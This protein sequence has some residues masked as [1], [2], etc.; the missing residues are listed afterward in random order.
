MKDA[1]AVA[2]AIEESFGPAA[3]AM[4]GVLRELAEAIVAGRKHLH[5]Y[6]AADAPALGLAEMGRL[7]AAFNQAEA[8]VQDDPEALSRVQVA[9]L[10]LR[11]LWARRWSELQQRAKLAGTPGPARPTT[12]R[13]AGRS[14]K[15]P[16]ATT[17]RRSRRAHRSLGLRSS[18]WPGAARATPPGCEALDPQH[19]DFQD[20]GFLFVQEARWAARERD[21]LASDGV[22]LRVSTNHREW[23]AQSWMETAPRETRY[24]YYASIRCEKTGTPAPPSGL[25][26][27]TSPTA[28][29]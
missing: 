1:A 28:R 25:A 12:R 7:E 13:T 11:Y 29:W 5:G 2:Q 22:A 18:A 16:G 20:D 3:P 6:V 27:T 23:A 14:S 17:S 4:L 19:L 15:W 8:A 9:R 10:P 21:D 26:S 24:T